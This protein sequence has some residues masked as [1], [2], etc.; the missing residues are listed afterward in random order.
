MPLKDDNRI[1]AGLEDDQPIYKQL[2]NLRRRIG[3]HCIGLS[4]NIGS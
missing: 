4:Q 1:A 3:R 2:E